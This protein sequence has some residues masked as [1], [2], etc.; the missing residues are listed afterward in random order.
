MPDDRAEGTFQVINPL[1]VHARVAS[2]LVLCA[3]R[4]RADVTL[5]R[6]GEED[7]EPHV[8]GKSIMGVLMLAAPKG[9]RIRV[10]AEGP[11]AGDAIK[12]IGELFAAGFNEMGGRRSG[13]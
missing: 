10:V 3:N 5:T 9:T 13:A 4:Y 12:A 1:G 6:E 11:D 2:M 8:N 7:G